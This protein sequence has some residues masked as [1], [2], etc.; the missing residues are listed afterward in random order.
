MLITLLVYLC[1]LAIIWWVV[2]QLPLPA[3]F[4]L[5][6]NVIVA[7]VAI[8]MLLQLTGVGGDLLSFRGRS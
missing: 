2:T 5:V 6:A 8:V 3:P 7:L 4:R 1:I